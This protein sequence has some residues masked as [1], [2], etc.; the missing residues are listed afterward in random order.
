M[1]VRWLI[2]GLLTVGAMAQPVISPLTP[3]PFQ[4]QTTQFTC[5]SNCG[6]GGTWS[7]SGAGSINSSSGLYTAPASVKAAQTYGGYQFLP[8]NIIYNTRIDSVGCPSCT[9]DT[10]TTAN[11]DGVMYG[12][13]QSGGSIT[14]SAGQT[15]NVAYNLDGGGT[16]ATGVVTLTGTNTIAPGTVIFQTAVGTGYHT[17]TVN[18]ATLSSGTATCSGV[19]STSAPGS[20]GGVVAGQYAVNFSTGYIIGNY[21]NN[22]TPTEN[23]SFANTPFDNAPFQFLPFP[24]MRVEGGWYS[25]RNGDQG[26]DHHIFR[27]STDTGIAQEQYQYYPVGSQGC[28]TCNSQSGAQYKSTDYTIPQGGVG[29]SGMQFLP[30]VLKASELINACESGTPINHSLYL[31]EPNDLANAASGNGYIWPATNTGGA[32]LPEAVMMKGMRL[33]LKASFDISTFSPCAQVILTTLKQYGELFYD[34]GIGADIS[35]DTDA[36]PPAVQ[37]VFA[38]ITGAHITGNNFEVVNESSLQMPGCV[39]DPVHFITC[40]NG[41]ANINRETVTYTSSSGSASVE[42]V[43]QGVA[44]DLAQHVLYMMVGVPAQQ[45]AAMVH[46]GGSNAVTWSMSPAVGTLTSG[47]LYTPPVSVS[48]PTKTTVKVSSAVDPSV[49]D[50]EDIWIFPST[51]MFFLPAFPASGYTD[52]HGN[53]WSIAGGGAFGLS[54]NAPV[55]GCCNTQGYPFFTGTDKQLFWD[56]FWSGNYLTDIWTKFIVPAGNYTITYNGGTVAPPG[57]LALTFLAQGNVLNATPIDPTTSVGQFG[58][59]S[60]TTT[61]T[62]GSNNLLTFDVF[63]GSEANATAFTG[64]ISSLSIVPG[65]PPPTGGSKVAPGNKAAQGVKIAAQPQPQSHGHV[66]P[67]MQSGVHIQYACTGRCSSE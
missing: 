63:G 6:T 33:R 57:S 47:G 9:V 2:I 64:D 35:T 56:E 12:V 31:T 25:A 7:V 13:Y 22:S 26:I 30:S 40:F 62:V 20:A 18:T 24:N 55:E 54:F 10:V 5:T 66:A 8:N 27:I 39:T 16:G 61:Q 21:T 45:L 58:H 3:A 32:N 28:P 44:V 59:Y 19:L 53:V 4:G 34:G 49:F 17:A 46:D 41:E 43:L 15:C 37:N 36:W 23:M 38:E 65:N 14:G 60:F 67:G 50:Q 29:A 48:G 51:G 42:V 1:S 11:L 52:S